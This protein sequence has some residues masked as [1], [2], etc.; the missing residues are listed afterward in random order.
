MGEMPFL[1]ML[2]GGLDKVEEELFQELI[3]DS[4]VNINITNQKGLTLAMDIAYKHN[5]LTRVMENLLQR[6]DLDMVLL[7]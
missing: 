2:Y 3:K 4:K 6:K 5:P 7:N 1:H